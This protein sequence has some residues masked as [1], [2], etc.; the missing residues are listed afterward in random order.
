MADKI[1]EKDKFVVSF[2][3][4]DGGH[5]FVT[6]AAAIEPDFIKS[7][8]PQ[9]DAW[10][11]IDALK[12]GS[13]QIAV[14]PFSNRIT[15]AEAATVAGLASG[16]LKILGQIQRKTNHVLVGLKDYI[17]QVADKFPDA[18]TYGKD[19][20][21]RTADGPHTSL[22]RRFAAYEDDT[23][24]GAKARFVLLLHVVFSSKS[25][26]DQ[27][28]GKLTSS[29]FRNDIKVEHTSN[30]MRILLRHYRERVT[31]SVRGALEAQPKQTS[32]QKGGY[33]AVADA[34]GNIV[35]QKDQNSQKDRQNFEM[36]I[37]EEFFS[38]ALVAEGLLSSARRVCGMGPNRNR[39][40]SQRLSEITETLRE[41]QTDYD[42]PF[43]LPN[44]DTTFLVVTS[45]NAKL[46]DKVKKGGFWESG[47]DA[48]AAETQRLQTDI[49]NLKKKVQ[50]FRAGI[51]DSDAKIVNPELS[52]SI[53]QTEEVGKA[54]LAAQIKECEAEIKAIQSEIDTLATKVLGPVGK[55]A[56]P[57]YRVAFLMS[58]EGHDSDWSK[59]FKFFEKKMEARFQHLKMKFDQSPELT[60]HHGKPVLLFSARLDGVS[61]TGTV[62]A[63]I[64]GFFKKEKEIK[65]GSAWMYDRIAGKDQ[66]FEP[67]LLGVYPSWIAHGRELLEWSPEG[68]SAPSDP[69]GRSPWLYWMTILTFVMFWVAVI[70][71]LTVSSTPYG[72]AW[73][74]GLG[75]GFIGWL[76]SIFIA[77][78]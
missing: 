32:T 12:N 21:R 52:A 11:A 58:V 22:A 17:I 59:A 66:K 23:P 20:P 5:S 1:E 61:G 71:V 49:E 28:R 43:D 37:D 47:D 72:R 39:L 73:L 50:Q 46:S 60:T 42:T 48:L 55:G 78:R 35:F 27:T 8:Q 41:L 30:P 62:E 9:E 74:F 24:D 67:K 13:A 53:R 45:A 63:D 10:G 18:Y 36:P 16:E 70:F 75:E 6:L 4:S 26:F 2:G 25:V 34:K 68:K 64:S 56:K 31:Q 7:V 40:C 57:S 65:T 15:S 38:A 33:E 19:A 44:N 14:L 77:P 54:N 3:E 29:D 76:A 69:T 51:V